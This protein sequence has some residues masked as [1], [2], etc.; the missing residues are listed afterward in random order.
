MQLLTKIKI[1]NMLYGHLP[2]MERLKK[3]WT[4]YKACKGIVK[5]E[6]KPEEL[7]TNKEQ[8]VP[9]DTKVEQLNLEPVQYNPNDITVVAGIAPRT[10]LN[11]V[12]VVPVTHK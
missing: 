10:Y 7:I 6:P 3:I 9:Y 11:P 1:E 8:F 2:I 5:T 4:R 12:I